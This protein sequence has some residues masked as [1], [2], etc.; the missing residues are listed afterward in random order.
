MI[1]TKRKR[2]GDSEENRMKILSKLDIESRK[3]RHQEL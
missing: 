2:A 3:P 1:K